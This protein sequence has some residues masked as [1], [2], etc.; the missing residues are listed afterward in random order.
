MEVII[1]KNAVRESLLFSPRL[2]EVF[3][4]EDKKRALKGIVSLAKSRN[5]KVNFLKK[6]DFYKKFPYPATQGVAAFA[7]PFP[8]LELGELLERLSLRKDPVLMVL[9]GVEDPQNFGSLLRSAECLGGDGVVIR[10][11][12]SVKVTTAVYKTSTGAV[13]KVP[14]AMVNNITACIKDLKKEGFWVFGAEAQV[15]K[16]IF[17]IDFKGK[18]ALVLGGEG[19]GLSRLVKEEC[20]E[21]F[22]IPLKGT[23]SS[24][25]VA[26]TGAIL[27]YEIMRRRSKNASSC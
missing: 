17:E 3:L 5:I 2:K 10:K 15:K 8:Y 16:T 24:L 20:D 11:R 1:G 7:E 4:I 6:E 21:L 19:R 26:V 25:N 18:I 22:S 23:I 9:D 14:I 27:L 13:E 12:R